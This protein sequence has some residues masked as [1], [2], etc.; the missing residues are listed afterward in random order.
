MSAFNGKEAVEKF[1]SQKFDLILMDVS[2]PIMDGIT[3][4][5]KIREYEKQL[6]SIK[7]Q[8]FIVGLSAYSQQETIDRAFEAGMNNFITKPATFNKII[9]IIEQLG[10]KSLQYFNTSS[11]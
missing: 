2:M 10:Q 8:V 3:A 7:S 4:T 1:K 6:G 9:R 11:M 5:T